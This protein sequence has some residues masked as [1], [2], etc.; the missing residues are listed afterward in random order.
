MAEDPFDVVEARGLTV[1]SDD[2]EV[3]PG[4]GRLQELYEALR[5]QHLC[6]VCLRGGV[7]GHHAL[8]RATENQH[9]V[10]VGA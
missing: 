1:G 5:E 2:E 10:E 7:H 9:E 6:A 3:D 8:E 4:V